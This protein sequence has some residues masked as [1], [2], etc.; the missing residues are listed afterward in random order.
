MNSPPKTV[1][2]Y[3]RSFPPD[4][5]KKLEELRKIVLENVSEA[6]E[7]I[8]WRMPSYK[9]HGYVIQF[10][11]FK[12]HIG[13]FPGPAAIDAFRPE[14]SHYKLSKG[15]IQLPLDEPIPADLVR[16]IIL[17]NVKERAKKI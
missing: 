2:E 1:D 4:V 14:L 16:K 15:T 17:Y 9:L 8:S 12:N 7:T 6:K 13:L 5:Q 3:I 10:A 11:A